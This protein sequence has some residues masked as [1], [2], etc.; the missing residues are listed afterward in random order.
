MGVFTQMSFLMG[1]AAFLFIFSI[2][3]VLRK[4]RHAAVGHV[5]ATFY[6]PTGAC[7]Q[8]LCTTNG[9][10]VDAPQRALASAPKV[11]VYLIQENKTFETLYP[12]GW[13]LWLKVSVPTI[14]YYEGSPEPIISR[15]PADRMVPVST[16][17]VVRA[18]RD[19]KFTGQMV[20]DSEERERLIKAARA[21]LKPNLVYL[22]LAISIMANCMMAYLVTNVRDQIAALAHLWGL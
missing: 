1:I 20:E 17:A 14:A 2:V 8:S 7:Y 6:T 13:P 5:W 10:T 15:D 16:P 18:L 3:R 9:Q 19:E 22:L 12:P 11:K 21:A 4:H